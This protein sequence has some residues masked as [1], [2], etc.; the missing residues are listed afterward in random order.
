MSDPLLPKITE[1]MRF[2]MVPGAEDRL[3][4]IF[5]EIANG[6]GDHG[7]FLKDF[8]RSYIRADIDNKRLL[9]TAAV[10]LVIKYDLQKHLPV[11]GQCSH[12]E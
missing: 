9:K 1:V 12:A 8:A 2:L 11:S 3:N 6:A 10:R 5:T 4:Y 7:D